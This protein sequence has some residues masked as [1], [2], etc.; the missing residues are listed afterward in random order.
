MKYFTR[1]GAVLGCSM[2]G[3]VKNVRYS[4]S[5]SVIRKV[6]SSNFII[7]RESARPRQV[8]S[9]NQEKGDNINICL[10]VRLPERGE[11]IES[12]GDRERK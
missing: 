12:N 1:T 9:W 11:N 7:F 3:S 8:F 2:Q 5:S 10:Y 6:D 4:G